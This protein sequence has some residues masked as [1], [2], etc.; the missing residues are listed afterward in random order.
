MNYKIALFTSLFV[1][2][3]MVPFSA[4]MVL[5]LG[6]DCHW[7]LIP[8]F[9]YE[10]ALALHHRIGEWGLFVVGSLRLS[11]A[12]FFILIGKRRALIISI[13]AVI[14]LIGAILAWSQRY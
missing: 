4:A 9:P 7:Y 8:V 5:A 13:V 6:Y 1:C 12:V 2:M 10:L 14:Q 11:F 3:I